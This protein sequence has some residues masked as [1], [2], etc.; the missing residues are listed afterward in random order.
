MRWC[1]EEEAIK[2]TGTGIAVSALACICGIG[3]NV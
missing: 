2:E 3:G 1:V